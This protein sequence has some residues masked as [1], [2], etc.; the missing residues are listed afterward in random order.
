MIVVPGKFVYVGSPRTG[1]HFIYD[2]LEKAF[3]EAKRWHEH[4]AFIADVLNAKRINGGIPVYTVIRDPVEWLFSFYWNSLRKYP[5]RIIEDTFETFIEGRK[6]PNAPY[7]KAVD[8]PPGR[9]A[10]Y[11]NVADKCFP[12]EQDFKTLFKALG[13]TDTHGV[14]FTRQPTKEYL[15]ARKMISEKDKLLIR[16]YFKHDYRLYKEL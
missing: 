13:V 2:V 15:E 10:T 9:L 1:S 6:P 5:N 12:F 14:E 7:N 16:K 4:H 3:P 8:F 11:Q